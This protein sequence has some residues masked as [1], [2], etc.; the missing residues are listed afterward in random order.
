MSRDW[1]ELESWTDE[2]IIEE[3]NRAATGT[4]AGVSF[5]LDYLFGR[6]AARQAESVAKMTRTMVCLTWVITGLT[7]VML[8]LTAANLWVVWKTTGH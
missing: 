2:R 5:Y 3:F 4:S 1:Q 7:A 6:M 8:I